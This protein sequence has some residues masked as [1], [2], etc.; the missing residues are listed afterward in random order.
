MVAIPIQPATD[1]FG[2]ARPQQPV[3]RD[4]A[5]GVAIGDFHQRGRHFPQIRTMIVIAHTLQLQSLRNAQNKGSRVH[6][7]GS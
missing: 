1:C 6:R 5:G 7:I 4:L 3:Q 2:F